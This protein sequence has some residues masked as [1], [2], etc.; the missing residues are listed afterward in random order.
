MSL[1]Q[2]TH[3][4]LVSHPSDLRSEMT[5]L[6]ITWMSSWLI[7]FNFMF[8]LLVNSHPGLCFIQFFSLSPLH[9]SRYSVIVELMF[10]SALALTALPSDSTIWQTQIHP[11]LITHLDDSASFQF[12]TSATSVFLKCCF[13]QIVSLLEDLWAVPIAHGVNTNFSA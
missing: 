11:L 5:P 10:L 12:F 8:I 4:E 3:L 7:S 13:S 6:L 1:H 2:F 9:H